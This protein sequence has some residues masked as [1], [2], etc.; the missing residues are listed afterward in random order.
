[1]RDIARKQSLRAPVQELNQAWWESNPMTYEWGGENPYQPG[2]RDWYAEIDRRFFSPSASFFAQDA[3]SPQPFSKLIPYATLTGKRV[4][5]VGCG[6]GAHAQQLAASGCLLTA[7]DL[8]DFAVQCTT[9]RLNVFGLTGSVMKMDAERM[10]FPDETF[11]FVWS[12]GVIHHSA[13][14]NLALDEIA[15]VLKPGGEARI[16]IY[17]RC[18]IIATAFLMRGWLTGKARTMSMDDILSH[19]IDGSIA[20]FYTKAEFTKELNRNFSTVRLQVFGQKNELY[21]LPGRGILGQVKRFLTSH[22]PDR[23]AA[24]VLSRF[25][26]FLFAVV[27]K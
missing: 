19:Y 4:L 5:E 12:W 27:T 13:H 23:L 22:T 3:R 18:S 26:N 8:T 7:I 21:P 1:M 15:R 24:S 25:G 14:M 20:R 17:H 9:E 11:D 6:S 10:T 2:T 16:M